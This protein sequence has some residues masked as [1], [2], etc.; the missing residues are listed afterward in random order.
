MAIEQ[1]LTILSWFENVQDDERPPE[2]IWED[3]KGL[4]LWWAS[5][6]AK[7][8]DGTDTSRG[9]SDHAH[10]DQAPRMTENDHARYLKEAM[11]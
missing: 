10:D 9:L 3:D 4:E 5:V 6:D 11:A 1:G 8:K 7:R 2:H